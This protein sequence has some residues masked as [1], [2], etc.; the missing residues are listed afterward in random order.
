MFFNPIYLETLS[1]IINLL[2]KKKV[3]GIYNVCS[4]QRISKY[5]FGKLL[6]KEFKKTNKY[7]LKDILI[8][9]N[10]VLRP[11]EMTLNNHK[12]KKTIGLKKISIFDEIKK[13]KNCKYKN[14]IQKIT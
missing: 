8:N 6:M 14:K 5:E 1:E 4:D 13:L 11:F 2:I 12:I 7:I 3:K 10:K 9:K